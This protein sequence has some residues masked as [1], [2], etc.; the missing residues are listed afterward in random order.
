MAAIRVKWAAGEVRATLRDTPT[1]DQ[2]LRALPLTARANVWGDEVYFR[3]PFSAEAEAD[4]ADVVDRGTVCFWLDGDSL[5]LLFGPTPVSRANECRLISAANVLGQIDS[6]PEVLRSVRGGE[7]IRV[8][9][10]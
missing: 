7:T 2:L 3:L 1:T 6:N 10:A 9:V 8:E 4:A 5:A